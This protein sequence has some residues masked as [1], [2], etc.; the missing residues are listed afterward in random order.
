MG[1]CLK[2]GNKT[3]GSA[4]FCDDCQ[5]VMAKYPVKPGA[6]AYLLPRPKRTERKPVEPQEAVI[7][8]KLAKLRRTIRWLTVLSIILSLLV[9]ATTYML[10]Q[11][12][13]K[14]EKKDPP[15]G[16]NYTTTHT[17]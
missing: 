8:A 12:T 16:K 3:K 11:E 13:M 2:C 7:K 6:V 10:I 15:I 4:V 9:L 5:A 1:N 17:P 14:E